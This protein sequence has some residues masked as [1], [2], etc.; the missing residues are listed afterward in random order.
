MI[1]REFIRQNPFFRLLLPLTIGIVFSH[2]FSLPQELNYSLVVIGL[3][4]IMIFIFLTK[5]R[6]SYVLRSLFGV[7]VFFTC[8]GAGGNRYLNVE[9]SMQMTCDNSVVGL[10]GNIVEQPVEKA[11]SYAVVFKV[12]QQKHEN[13]WQNEEGK[14]MLYLQ[15]DKRVNSLIIGDPLMLNSSIRQVKNLGN[16]YEFD[17]ASYLKTQ[18][19][20]YTA[21]VD[22]LSWNRVGNSSHFSFRVV[23]AKWRDKLLDIYRKNGIKDE[24][25]DILA[26]LTLGYKTSLD[27]DTKK[28][29]ANAGAMHVLAVSRL[30]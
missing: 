21:Y 1:L 3:L 25:F 30:E 28:A 22:S 23:A 18:H 24:S 27:P 14:V 15:K 9:S 8:I 11:N 10:L 17:Y 26:A 16:P 20:L 6:K 19:I 13:V 12:K 29:W 4:G 7:F 5:L 2:A